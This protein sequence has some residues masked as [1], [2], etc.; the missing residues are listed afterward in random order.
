[1]VIATTGHVAVC[2]SLSVRGAREGP[3]PARNSDDLPAPEAPTTMTNPPTSAARRSLPRSCRVLRSRPK[4]QLLSDC[5]NGARPRYGHTLSSATGVSA[6]S[7]FCAELALIGV[8]SACCQSSC[9]AA[10]S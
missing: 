8:A 4:N 5:R 3:S 6:L 9:H 7:V 1:G 2:A 10:R